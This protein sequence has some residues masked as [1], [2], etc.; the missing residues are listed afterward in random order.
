MCCLSSPSRQCGSCLVTILRC[1]TAR[2]E[3][4]D[5]KEI[6]LTCVDEPYLSFRTV[7]SSLKLADFHRSEQVPR[8]QRGP[9]GLGQDSGQA[10]QGSRLHGV[11][12]G[13]HGRPVFGGC[14]AIFSCVSWS[15]LFHLCESL[16]LLCNADGTAYSRG[17]YEDD[18]VCPVAC[19]GHMIRVA[20]L[21]PPPHSTC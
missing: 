17:C 18:T 5:E 1:W 6:S 11:G 14:P 10:L 16:L 4:L 21:L 19:E 2:G 13:P 3:P 8:E 9:H 20:L 12:R 15:K 7:P